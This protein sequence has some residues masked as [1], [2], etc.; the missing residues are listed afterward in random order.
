MIDA[1]RLDELLPPDDYDDG[2][3]W[4]DHFAGEMRDLI[5]L[6][7]LGLWAQEHR[8]EIQEALASMKWIMAFKTNKAFDGKCKFDDALGDFLEEFNNRGNG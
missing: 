2:Y 6:A 5:Q 4:M 1:K 8:N 7:K 3:C